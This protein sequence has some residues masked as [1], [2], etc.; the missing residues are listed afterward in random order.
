MAVAQP[1]PVQSDISTKAPTQIVASKPVQPQSNSMTNAQTKIVAT[2]P[3]PTK[4]SIDAK[5]PSKIVPAQPTATKIDA[6][7]VSSNNSYNI[8]IQVQGS[9]PREIAK[10]VKK[11]IVQMEQSR[12]NRSYSDMEV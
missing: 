4:N 7:S 9:D 11:V 10:E 3:T 2:Q 5:L 8:T 6:H 1:A 12:K